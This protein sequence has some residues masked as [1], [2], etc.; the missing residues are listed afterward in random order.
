MHDALLEDLLDHRLNPCY[1]KIPGSPSYVLIDDNAVE[2]KAPVRV[3]VPMTEVT[4]DVEERTLLLIKM[5]AENGSIGI[6]WDGSFLSIHNHFDTVHLPFDVVV[7]N[8]ETKIDLPPDI[9]YIKHR[10]VTADRFYCLTRSD[11]LGRLPRCPGT[12][13]HGLKS[14]DK[15]GFLIFNPKGILTVFF[16]PQAKAVDIQAQA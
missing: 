1:D 14:P 5:A 6:E 7:K 9:K 4:D 12:I 3:F 13:A 10:D 8:P 15:L 2:I 16:E 11:L